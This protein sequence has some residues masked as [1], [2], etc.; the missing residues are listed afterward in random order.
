MNISIGD[1]YVCSSNEIYRVISIQDSKEF[2]EDPVIEVET[3]LSGIGFEKTGL[4]L[5]AQQTK[6]FNLKHYKAV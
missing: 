4:T 3:Y 5:T 2:S 1:I 6:D